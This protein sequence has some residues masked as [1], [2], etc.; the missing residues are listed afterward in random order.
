[1]VVY[2][3]LQRYHD[4][5]TVASL[6]RNA[7]VLFCSERKTQAVLESHRM[8]RS[9]VVEHE[10]QDD[11]TNAEVEGEGDDEAQAAKVGIKH[12]VLDDSVS[13]QTKSTIK[14]Q[15][16]FTAIFT[17]SDPEL[18]DIESSDSAVNEHY[19]WDFF[20]LSGIFIC[21][22]CGRQWFREI[23]RQRVDHVPCRSQQQNTLSE[24]VV[25]PASVSP[26][27]RRSSMLLQNDCEGHAAFPHCH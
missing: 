23:H 18:S 14:L 13:K 27:K 11:L 19:S 1:M 21:G 3:A 10:L 25:R 24:Y 9:I 12:D 7:Y 22:R 20:R 15:S 2:A 6:Y 17:E 26:Q 8:I 16:P 4:K 5:H